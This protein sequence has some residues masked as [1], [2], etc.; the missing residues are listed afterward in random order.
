MFTSPKSPKVVSNLP[1]LGLSKYT[2]M[3]IDINPLNPFKLPKD[4]E[5]FYLYGEKQ[6]QK[7]LEKASILKNLSLKDRT[8][9]VNR[10]RDGII[11]TINN[12]E[13]IDP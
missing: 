4:N 9:A 5:V 10:T 12:I 2:G 13:P 1:M 11:R 7:A 6:R 8:L 3:P